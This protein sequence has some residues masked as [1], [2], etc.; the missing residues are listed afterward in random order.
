MLRLAHA[1]SPEVAAATR[2]ALVVPVGAL[3][4]HGPHLPLNTD[5]AIAT[6]VGEAVAAAR[7]AAA[8]A[9]AVPVGASGEHAA[10]A[11]TLS[12]GTEALTTVLVELVRD[13]TR[14]WPA[15]LLLN[16]HGGNATALARA[17]Q[18][19]DDEGRPVG[20]VHLGVAGM[21]AH[22]GRAETSL[23]L[24]LAPERVALDRAAAGPTTPVA[25]LLP[26]LVAGGVRAVSATGVL[27]DPAGASAA[28]G[29]G[30]LAAL[31]AKALAAHDRL[32]G[33]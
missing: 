28:E 25:D 29:A 15:V 22:A 30:H 8:L 17:A 13:A 27:G 2:G 6:A 21:D 10:F 11:G 23:M 7:P 4:Q 9:P 33:R 20:V 31:V 26:T 19:C 12:I 14:D 3:E 18:I 24:H 16:G 32:V 5:T 1:R